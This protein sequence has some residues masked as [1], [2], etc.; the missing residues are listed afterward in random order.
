[1]FIGAMA[2]FQTVPQQFF[3]ASSRPELM[4]DLWLP[5]AAS[6]K[7][8]DEAVSRLEKALRNDPDVEA[9]TGYIG[10]GSPRGT[11]PTTATPCA[12]RSKMAEAR[13]PPTTSTRA[14]GIAGTVNRSARITASATT[15]TRS[16]IQ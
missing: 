1:M 6:I 14:P 16:V 13:R 9:V 5:E 11:S 3:P 15:P 4:V 8:T 7:A 10:A 12:L 2:L